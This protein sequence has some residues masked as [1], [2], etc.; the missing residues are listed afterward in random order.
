MKINE[1]IK[2]NNGIYIGSVSDD[3]ALIYHSGVF[4]VFETIN[5]DNSVKY[6][7]FSDEKWR[8]GKYKDIQFLPVEKKYLFPVMKKWV[9]NIT[10]KR[11][12]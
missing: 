12:V 6:Q 9:K 5:P 1:V 4:G 2:D 10:Q 3:I 8:F 7:F 11:K